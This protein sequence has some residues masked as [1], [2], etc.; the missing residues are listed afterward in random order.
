MQKETRGRKELSDRND[1]RNDS[2]RVSFSA[3][4]CKAHGSRE[5]LIEALYV[6]RNQPNEMNQLINKLQNEASDRCEKEA[7]KS[8]K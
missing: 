6:A 4:D 8:T 7:L 5:K 1:V 3:N 2:K